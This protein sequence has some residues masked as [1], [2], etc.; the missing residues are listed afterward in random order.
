MNI[1][2][3]DIAASKGIS[4][5]LTTASSGHRPSADADR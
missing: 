5:R 3:N 2:L 1:S 4:G